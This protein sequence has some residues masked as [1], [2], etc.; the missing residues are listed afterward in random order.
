MQEAANPIFMLITDRL[1]TGEP[2]AKVGTIRNVRISNVTATEVVAGRNHGPAN[3]STISG[4][5]D[6]KLENIVL[7]NVKIT[8]K[9]GSK[10]EEADIV[11]PYPKDRY[12]PNG[13]GLRPASGFYI[14]HVKGLTFRN[15]EFAFESAEP[16]PPLVV[17]DVDGFELDNF[18][19]PKSSG[20]EIMRLEQVKNLNV[21][22]SP[23]LKE[24]NAAVV[25]K[26]RE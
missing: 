7:E 16:K 3:A 25:D 1:R 21:R 15:V 12:Q 6:A 9:G 18:K 10:P 20:G 8:Y 19:S 26:A 4:R 5:P 22:N 13:M 23:G 24:R 11:P 14:R 2:G 17:F